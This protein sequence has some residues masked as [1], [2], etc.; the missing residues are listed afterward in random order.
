MFGGKWTSRFTCKGIADEKCYWRVRNS[1]GKQMY[2]LLFEGLGNP[3][4]ISPH[5]ARAYVVIYQDRGI[6]EEHVNERGGA[7]YSFAMVPLL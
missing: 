3:K 4:Q 7:S 2:C 6:S 1:Q 5:L